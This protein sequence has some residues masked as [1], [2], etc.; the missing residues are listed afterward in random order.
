MISNMPVPSIS[1]VCGAA[2]GGGFELALATTFRVFAPTASVGLPETRLGIIPGA[3]GTYRIQQVV[4][5]ARALHMLLTGRRMS[6]EEAF[7]MNLCD[8]LTGPPLQHEKS[9]DMAIHRRRE[10]LHSAVEMAKDICEGAPASTLVLTRMFNEGASA[11]SEAEAY[12]RVL[13]TEDRDEGLKAFREKRKPVFTGK[14][15]KARKELSEKTEK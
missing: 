15:K 2:L 1:A 12:E 13:Q 3:G 8:R 14:L 11:K 5:K 4:S 7:H 10:I 6:G 9:G